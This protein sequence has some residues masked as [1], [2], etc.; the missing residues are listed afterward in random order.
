[1]LE[2]LPSD[3]VT[4]AEL[5]EETKLCIFQSDTPSFRRYKEWELKIGV[6]TASRGMRVSVVHSRVRLSR[7]NLSL[8]ANDAAV[9]KKSLT[10][11]II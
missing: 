2:R 6:F 10:A 1:M 9:R 8:I 4:V 3:Q 7:P 5:P 11:H